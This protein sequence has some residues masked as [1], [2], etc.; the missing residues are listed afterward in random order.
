MLGEQGCLPPSCT[1]S[2]AA[3]SS[4]LL[5]ARHREKP[6]QLELSPLDVNIVSPINMQRKLVEVALAVG[7]D[8]ESRDGPSQEKM[9]V[10]RGAGSAFRVERE[11]G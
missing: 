6:R 8:Q 1:S 2:P 5:W 4:G 11:L 3:Q 7:E 9:D 10:P